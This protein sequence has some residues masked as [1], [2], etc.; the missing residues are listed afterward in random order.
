MI[1]FATLKGFATSKG[2]VTQIARD[3]VVLWKLLTSK[4]VILQVEKITSDTYAGETTYT[5]EQ[6]VLLNIYPKTN[7]TVK[8]TYG[9]LTKTITDASGA[10]SPNAQQVFFGTFNGV[11]DS[12]STPA[13]GTVT[14]EGDVNNF[15]VGSYKK[16]A[17][18]KSSTVY[19]GCIESVI[20][21]GSVKEIMGFAFNSCTSLTNIS[22]PNGITNIGVNAFTNCTSLKSVSLPDSITGIGTG[23]FSGCTSLTNI[24]LPNSITSIGGSA[25]FGC[26]SLT[27]VSLPNSITTIGDSAFYNC[28]KI[29]FTEMPTNL[30]AIGT[31]AFYMNT[32]KVLDIAMNGKSVTLPNT[33]QSI[34]SDAFN[35]KYEAMDGA[36]EYFTYLSEVRI[37]ATTPPSI[38]DDTFG[39]G[40]YSSDGT[41]SGRIE[42]KMVVPA[43]C[44]D[45]YVTGWAAYGNNIVEAS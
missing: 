34:G 4:P 16:F 5:G 3:G 7:G 41:K 6:F 32:T 45:I 29:M 43:G 24:S 18:N 15:A 33:I 30:V 38:S 44:K 22:L 12:V 2:N 28:Q 13:S 9:G 37:L 42:T 21:W 36:Y 26:T 40:A 25:F 23:M 35:T 27:N 20:E 11:S 39:I 10:E 14:I 31:S 1:N 8:V 19:C 17:N